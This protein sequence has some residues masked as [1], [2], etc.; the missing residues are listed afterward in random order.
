[1]VSLRSTGTTGPNRIEG[2]SQDQ[3]RAREF[4]ATTPRR[5]VDPIAWEFRVAT[6]SFSSR[7]DLSRPGLS[8][9]PCIHVANPLRR[10]AVAVHPVAA[11]SIR[12]TLYSRRDPVASPSRRGSKNEFLRS[13]QPSGPMHGNSASRPV[14]FV[15]VAARSIPEILYSRREPVLRRRVVAV[16]PVAAR[17]IRGTLYSRRDP[18][19]SPRRC[20]S[21]CIV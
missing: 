4:T 15:P 7:F 2:R 18:V 13:P 11:R 6:P 1:M 9:E 12:G 5:H 8:E 10:R 16:H 17:S 14:A 19:A 21:S 3:E 20:G